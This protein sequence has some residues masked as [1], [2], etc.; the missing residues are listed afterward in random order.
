[1][2]QSRGHQKTGSKI[3]LIIRTNTL[4]LIL[5]THSPTVSGIALLFN[6]RQELFYE[7]LPEEL[8][9]EGLPE[10]L[11]LFLIIRTNTIHSFTDR[12]WNSPFYAT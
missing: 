3:I 8:F 12:E 9:R 4:K 7:G 10:E 5:Y 11:K 6:L 1:M 2:F